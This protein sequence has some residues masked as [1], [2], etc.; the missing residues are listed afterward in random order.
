M[1]RYLEIDSYRIQLNR[2]SETPGYL[3]KIT[4]LLHLIHNEYTNTRRIHN[5]YTNNTCSAVLLYSNPLIITPTSSPLLKILNTLFAYV[6]IKPIC[7]TKLVSFSLNQLSHFLKNISICL[8]RDTKPCTILCLNCLARHLK[9]SY[10]RNSL[11]QIQRQA[12][13]THSRGLN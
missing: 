1:Q 6:L 9:S 12:K 3:C 11:I 7:S 13:I 5:S 8:M 10:G 2:L 4:C